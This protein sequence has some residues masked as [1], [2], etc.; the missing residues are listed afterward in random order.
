MQMSN[1]LIVWAAIVGILLQFGCA[2]DSKFGCKN[3][4]WAEAPTQVME[5]TFD[6]ISTFYTLLNLNPKKDSIPLG[7]LDSVLYH[8]E[9]AVKIYD[10]FTGIGYFDKQ[11]FIMTGEILHLSGRSNIKRFFMDWPNGATDTLVLDYEYDSERDNPCCCN[12]PLQTFTING[13]S[14]THTTGNYGWYYFAR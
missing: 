10:T 6:S 12:F 11:Y 4:R 13:K 14:F 2:S 1:K 8:L 3:S 5:F 7:Y 9:G